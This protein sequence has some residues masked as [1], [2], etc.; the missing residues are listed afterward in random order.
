[1]VL[2]RLARKEAETR[3]SQ[4]RRSVSIC[5]F[6]HRFEDSLCRD[7]RQLTEELAELSSRL[8]V[9]ICEA[10]ESGDLLR[11][12][13]IDT[14]PAIVFAVKD[15]PELRMYGLPLAFGFDMLLDLLLAAATAGEPKAELVQYLTAHQTQLA[16]NPL[17]INLYV[18]RYQQN[19]C[20]AAAVLWRLLRAEQAVFGTN[21]LVASIRF[22]EEFP[23][24][25]ISDPSVASVPAVVSPSKPTVTWPFSDE[26]LAEIIL[27]R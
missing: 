7:V 24:A 2:N 27:L 5:V 17:P 15:A 14:L 25:G 21:H 13:R 6:T 26:Q 9:E 20:E 22:V 4:L 10:T 11:K 1:M 19:S 3:F 12:Y 16:V 23:I 18:S 8:S